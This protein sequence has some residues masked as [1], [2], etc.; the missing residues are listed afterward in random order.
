LRLAGI[1]GLRREPEAEAVDLGPQVVGGRGK[2]SRLYALQLLLM[3][4]ERGR[5][6]RSWLPRIEECR[7]EG[8][9]HLLHIQRPEPVAQAMAR[10]LAR[11]PMDSPAASDRRVTRA[12]G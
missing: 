6:L 12:S 9:G 5:D 8:V 10:F 2:E 3:L 4:S 1:F 11:H 7:I